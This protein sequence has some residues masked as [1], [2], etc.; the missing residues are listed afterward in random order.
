[1][2]TD[3]ATEEVG[4]EC[5]TRKSSSNSDGRVHFKEVVVD[6]V[7]KRDRVN[8]CMVQCPCCGNVNHHGLGSHETLFLWGHRVCDGGNGCSGYVLAPGAVVKKASHREWRK[9]S[10][11]LLKI[12]KDRY[13]EKCKKNRIER[14]GHAKQR[15]RV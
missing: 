2:L 5:Q 13:K 10:K 4:K 9:L 6:V 7:R 15:K 8:T 3:V 12:E 14:Y 1:M 11:P